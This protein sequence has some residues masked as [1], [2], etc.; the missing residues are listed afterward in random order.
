MVTLSPLN[1]ATT[2]FAVGVEPLAL[3]LAPNG[4]RLYVA[5]SASNNL[6]VFDTATLTPARLASAHPPMPQ[7]TIDLSGMG[8]APSGSPTTATATIVTRPSL[9][10]S[11]LLSCG[12]ASRRSTKD[13]MTNA[14]GVS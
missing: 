13:K 12:P 14:R 7:N 9:S 2:L 8:S 10:R 1:C 3:A 6:M 5:N 11:S 4:T